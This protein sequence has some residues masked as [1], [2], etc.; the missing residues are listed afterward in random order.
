MV[1]M[2]YPPNDARRDSGFTTFYMGINAGAFFAPIICGTLIGAKFGYQWGFFAAGVGMILGLLVFHL[3]TGWLGHIGESPAK[4]ETSG[5]VI[6]VAIGCVASVPVVYLMLSQKEMVGYILLALMVL[7]AVYFIGSA[8]KSGDKVQQH[9]GVTVLLDFVAALD[10]AADEIK[11]KAYHQAK[12][13]IA[14]QFFLA[15]R[16]KHDRHRKQ[17]ADGDLEYA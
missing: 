5:R 11:R 17:A 4:A 13:D 1:G 9:R 8:I 14:N 16:K 12:Q 2:L 3:L 15:E 7:L 10:C 6:K